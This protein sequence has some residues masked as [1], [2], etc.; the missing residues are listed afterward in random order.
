MRTFFLVRKFVAMTFLGKGFSLEKS[1]TFM[2][3]TQVKTVHLEEFR[4]IIK[5]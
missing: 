5:P 1:W 3:L 4:E 2:D